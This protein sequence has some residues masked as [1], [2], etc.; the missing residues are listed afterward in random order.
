MKNSFL[1]ISSIFIFFSIISLIYADNS[2]KDDT[3]CSNLYFLVA[4]TNYGYTD[5]QL[6]NINATNDDVYSYSEICKYS[7]YPSLPEKAYSV[8]E[9][10]TQEEICDFQQ[11]GLLFINFPEIMIKDWNCNKL[12]FYSYFMGINN[13]KGG[14]SIDSIRLWFLVVLL[15]LILLI[16]LKISK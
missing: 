13:Q 7:N 12:K 1:L 4:Q 3:F 16:L 6:Q 14:Y 10:G 15:L 11:H 2:P 8:I 5:I 9:T